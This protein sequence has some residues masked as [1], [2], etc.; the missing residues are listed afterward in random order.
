M[1]ILRNFEDIRRNIFRGWKKGFQEFFLHVK[2]LPV[3]IS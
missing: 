3:Q 2:A 1:A